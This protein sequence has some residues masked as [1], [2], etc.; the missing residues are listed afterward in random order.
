METK[1]KD[2]EM[3]IDL[4]QIF[5]VILG[6]IGII[7]LTGITFALVSFLVFK[8]GVTKQYTS[9]AQIYVITKSQDAGMTS[10]DVAVSTYLSSDYVELITTRPVMEQVISELG[11]NMTSGQLA[12]KIS[13]S[14]V[15]SSRIIS[16]DAVDESPIM[17]KRIVDCVTSISAERICKVMDTEVVNI[18]QD[19]DVP[20]S[21]S[22][23]STMKNTVL[24]FI[25]G[26]FLSMVVVIIKFMLD[27]RICTSEDIEK[28]L[29]LS[30][31][32]TIPVFDQKEEHMEY[33][34]SV[35]KNHK[36][37]KSK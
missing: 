9:N 36:I 20:T 18:V 14:I 1:T 13:A 26:I 34:G 25:L 22:S 7:L 37:I 24:A 29:G 12:K 31:M 19:G 15:S 28:Y 11:L 32:G 16:I 33:G 4:Q 2:A 27:D 35:V 10:S 3:E 30:V 21:P 17:A 6:R 5:F 8:F 23:P